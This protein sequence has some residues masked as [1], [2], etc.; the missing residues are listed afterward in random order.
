MSSEVSFF[1]NKFQSVV[2]NLN[3]I[4]IFSLQSNLEIAA[5]AASIIESTKY[6][7]YMLEA[8]GV[9]ESKSLELKICAI[10]FG[11]VS[12]SG[13]TNCYEDD[14]IGMFRCRGLSTKISMG[15]WPPPNDS[16]MLKRLSRDLRLGVMKAMS[17]MSVA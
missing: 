3:P 15:I 12:I 6:F 7:W 10:V 1:F 17:K 5:S 11:N 8:F 2:I 13:L 16:P 9:S 4:S 14:V